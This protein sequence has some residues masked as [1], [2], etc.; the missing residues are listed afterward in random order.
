MTDNNTRMN[1]LIDETPNALFFDQIF[2]AMEVAKAEWLN[3][4]LTEVLRSSP[5]KL[6]ML[7][8]QIKKNE[9]FKQWRTTGLSTPK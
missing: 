1:L 6:S 7:L 3:L 2:E 4:Y 5:L 9:R 8:T